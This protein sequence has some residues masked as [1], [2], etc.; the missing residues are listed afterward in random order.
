MVKPTYAN[1]TQATNQLTKV[2]TQIANRFKKYGDYLIFETMNEPR[3]VG[4]SN[5]WTGG[6]S[7]NRD[8]INKYNLAAVNT[9]RNTGGNNT[10]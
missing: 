9:I 8:V 1:Q 5:E 10:S 7:E 2:W 6:S 4:A 3:P